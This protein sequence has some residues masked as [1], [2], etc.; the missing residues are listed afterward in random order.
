MKSSISE[1]V[2]LQLWSDSTPPTA[3]PADGQREG[4]V[5]EELT[6]EAYEL[7]H[8]QTGVYV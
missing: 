7:S 6:Y 4:E 2:Y 5:E 3:V 1:G 8:P